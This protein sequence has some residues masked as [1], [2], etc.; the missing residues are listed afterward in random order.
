MALNK[1]IWLSTL[2]ENFYPANSFTAKSIDDSPFV[3]NHTVHIPNAGKPS[4]VAINRTEKPAAIKEREDKDL[5]YSIDE[6]T[7]DP[8]HISNIDTV[9]LSYDKRSSILSND[10]QQLQKT[11]AQNLLYR[12]AEKVKT[13]ILTSGGTR[14]AHTSDTSTGN[15]KKLTKAAVMQAMIKFNVD[16]V[17][18]EGRYILVDS[19]MYADLLDDLTDKELSAFLASADAQSGVLGKLYGFE[20]MQRS[21]VLRVKE[22]D[23][24]VL[25]WEEQGEATELSAGIIW[26]KD[27]VSR[28]IGEIT[29][30]EDM[31]NPTYYGDIFSFL[32]RTGGAPRRHD[33]KGIILL[34]EDTSE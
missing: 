31:G 5:T 13:H 21:Q 3:N 2:V 16:D 12:W 30:F 15:R 33:G 9:E 4:N 20:I 25:K 1:E 10:R 7:T 28:A 26:Q 34:V 24:T 27:C 32:V 22:T 17:P 8:I 18:N 23:K 6:L 29:M 14:E 19:I 11:A